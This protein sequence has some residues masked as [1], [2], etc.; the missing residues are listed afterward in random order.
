MQS[1]G[2]CDKIDEPQNN[3]FQSISVRIISE[4]IYG[5]ISGNLVSLL[6]VHQFNLNDLKKRKVKLTGQRCRYNFVTDNAEY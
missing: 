3:S 5:I 6:S 2:L 4:I 1:F